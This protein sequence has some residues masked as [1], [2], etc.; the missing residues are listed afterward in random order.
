MI[1]KIPLLL[2]YSIIILP[3]TLITGPAIPDITITFTGIFFLLLIFLHK[4]YK[5]VIKKKFFLYSIFFWLYLVFISFFAENYYLSFRDALIFIRI[6]FIPI[7]VYYWICKDTKYIRI[8][9]G[10]IFISVVFVA[11]DSLYQFSQYDPEYGFGKDILGFRTAWYGRLTGP[12]KDELIP[13]AYLTK[14]GLLGIIFL[15]SNINNI[16]YK[17]ISTIIYLVIL[18]AAI[19]ASG[20]RMALATFLMGI[21]FL[22]IFYRSNRLIFFSSFLIILSTILIIFKS[23]PI[24]N[25][26]TVIESTP[27]H[28][29][30]KVEKTFTCK[31]DVKNNCKKII[32]LQ[33]SFIKVIKNFDQSAYG[34]IY[35]LGLKM[36]KDHKF[37]GI[38]LNNFTFLCNNDERY[39]NMLQNYNCTTHPHNIYL[40]WLI[41]AGI[42]GFLIFIFYVAYLFYHILKKNYNE[43]S[44]VSVAT[45]M[46]IFWPIMST[47]SLLKNW[48][49][50]GIFFIIGVCLALSKIKNTN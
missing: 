11:L 35:N 20:E 38:G 45:I 21:I 10:I 27:Y 36:F 7:F 47:G 1:N 50:V 46:V 40:Q 16:A 2:I 22:S 49:G 15:F 48:N 12:F 30:L 31:N 28:N 14:F 33:P 39:N 9:I 34:E 24:Y 6:L 41:E 29:G 8:I 42:I 25:D 18:G 13:G 32:N 44:L 37:S 43:Y 17:N 3:I 23:H 4:E 19:F 5:F 26:F